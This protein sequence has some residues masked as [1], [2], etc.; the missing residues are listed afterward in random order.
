MAK[1]HC[2]QVRKDA[3]IKQR[4]QETELHQL[5]QRLAELVDTMA[6]S[7]HIETMEAFRIINTLITYY[8]S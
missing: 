4:P 6:E 3:G 2:K 8:Q 7:R 1:R 5:Y